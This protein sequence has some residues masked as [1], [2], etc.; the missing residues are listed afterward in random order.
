MQARLET[1][2][3]PTRPLWEPVPLFELPYVIPELR[4]D[5][6]RLRTILYRIVRSR[7]EL[8]DHLK[9]VTTVPEMTKII[10]EIYDEASSQEALEELAQFH[11]ARP[12]QRTLEET[13][14]PEEN[15]L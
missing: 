10:W 7:R 3:Q 11:S 1:K 9:E 8:L 14:F 6:E 4:E 12:G 13:Q 5:V 2:D 15:V